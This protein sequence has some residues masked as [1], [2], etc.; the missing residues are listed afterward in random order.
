MMIT[1][2][3]KVVRVLTR[4]G[5]S[6][7][8]LIIRA[9]AAPAIAIKGRAVPS[10]GSV[11][12]LGLKI[13]NISEKG[14]KFLAAHGKSG[15]SVEFVLTSAKVSFQS[16]LTMLG[17]QDCVITIPKFLESIE[18]RKNARYA[19][20]GNARAFMSIE[21]WQPHIRDLTSPPTWDSAVDF[22]SLIPL[23][24]VSLG[25]ISLVTPFP[26][27]TKILD[28]GQS[29]EKGTLYFPMTN[30][31][32]VECSVR[33]CKKVRENVVDKDGASRTTRLYRFGLQFMNPGYDLMQ[34]VQ[35]LIQKISQS[36]AI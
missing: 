3:E 33:W 9:M 2:P 30:G 16:E 1:S 31:I 10:T 22:S 15:I 27:I 23:G 29:I 13:G 32:E 25:G 24:D 14:I 21:G 7:I 19:V 20:T 34:Q 11:L 17:R 6:G 26:G 8:P 36:E 4:L 35:I 5:D 18:R 28:G 12:E